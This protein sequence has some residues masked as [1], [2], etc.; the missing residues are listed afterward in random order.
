[1]PTT[2]PLVEAILQIQV[3]KWVE[4]ALVQERTGAEKRPAKKHYTKWAMRKLKVRKMLAKLP[5][6]SEDSRPQTVGSQ[7]S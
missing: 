3:K 4:S 5:K 7:Q 2:C 6:R 1:M